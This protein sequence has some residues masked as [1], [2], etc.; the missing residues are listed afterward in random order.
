MAREESGHKRGGKPFSRMEPTTWRA[1]RPKPGLLTILRPALR[2]WSLELLRKK[3]EPGCWSTMTT[4]TEEIDFGGMSIHPRRNLR[5]KL[6]K[7]FTAAPTLSLG[8]CGM[9][10]PE[11]AGLAS[12]PPPSLVP[13]RRHRFRHQTWEPGHQLR[14]TG[15]KTDCQ[16]VI[17]WQQCKGTLK[18]QDQ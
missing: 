14:E 12:L 15:R 6:Q 1:E 3:K 18:L 2:T 16:Q 4:G 9:V 10:D 8:Q 7:D 17:Q 11:K 5:W 13:G